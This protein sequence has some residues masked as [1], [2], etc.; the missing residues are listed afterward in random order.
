[1]DGGSAPAVPSSLMCGVAGKGGIMTPVLVVDDSEDIRLVVREVLADE[2]YSVLEAG[3]GMDALA[4][5]RESPRPLLVL[6]DDRLPGLSGT[7]VL[8]RVAG[9]GP[10]LLRHAYTLM[11]TRDPGGQRRP[12]P[13][14]ASLLPKPFDLDDLLARVAGMERSLDLTG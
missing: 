5:L 12:F 6:L 2:G 11:S 1:M 8:E 14:P 3:D 13:V 4:I 9:A 10:A 7:E